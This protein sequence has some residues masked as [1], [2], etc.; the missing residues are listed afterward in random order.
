MLLQKEFVRGGKLELNRAV[1]EQDVIRA[2]YEFSAQQ[3]RVT[4]SVTVAY[5]DGLIAQRRS[6]LARQL[7]EI[8]RQGVDTV[9]QLRKAGESS[10]SD[11]LQATLELESA[12]LVVNSAT[13]RHE[14]A[15]V[16]A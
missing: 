6:E 16:T 2:S 12:E 7:V 1:A 5:Y 8:A 10:R 11:L 9:E 4:T 3:Q 15:L 13:V 14:S